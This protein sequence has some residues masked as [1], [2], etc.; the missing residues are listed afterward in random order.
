MGLRLAA[1]VAVSVIGMSVLLNH[2][3]SG[4]SQTTETRDDVGPAPIP[5]LLPSKPTDAPKRHPVIS[6]TLL[7]F[8]SGD[9]EAALHH[10]DQQ[11][12]ENLPA[13]IISWLQAQRPHIQVSLG[14][15][16]L[17]QKRCPEAISLFRS[18]M[19]SEAGRF[20]HKGL[21]YCYTRQGYD[22]LALQ[23]LEY[24]LADAPPEDASFYPTM[25]DLLESHHEYDRAAKLIENSPRGLMATS[26]WKR[27]FE[28]LR[29]K[30][31]M[32]E[33]QDTLSTSEF[34]LTYNGR[35]HRETAS[36]VLRQLETGLNDLL[37]FFSFRPP[38]QA[39]EVVLHSSADLSK[40]SDAPHWALGLFDGRI[41]LRIDDTAHH[42]VAL[43]STI[44]HELSHAL[45]FQM[46]GERRLPTWFE[47][48]L[49]QLVECAPND[50][51]AFSY[52]AVNQAF[53]STDSFTHSFTEL[54]ELD[55]RLAYHQSAFL[56]RFLLREAGL[57][58]LSRV[59]ESLQP[60]SDL[61]SDVLLSLALGHPTS[62]AKY[63][64]GAASHWQ[65][66]I[67]LSVRR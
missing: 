37:H 12:E 18:G 4:T 1:L 16:R 13:A 62:F 22:D 65:R 39:I 14:W 33:H 44:R 11:L 43:R 32:T 2:V 8:N 36:F 19:Q 63:R 58:G 24:Y 29:H 6:K 61:Q 59:L 40:S 9:Y 31:K 27:K 52:P 5:P 17:K 41:R 47:E 3:D 48:G 28:Q 38:S 35:S 57:D 54:N 60:T 51:G 34:R 55:A 46:T 30:S 10:V 56:L 23:H 67:P 45:L 66:R 20:A 26:E 49:A 50:C 21:V 64:E 42:L 7:F 53:L 25:I 15:L